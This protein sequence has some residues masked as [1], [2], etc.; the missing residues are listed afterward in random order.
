VPV[1]LVYRIYGGENRKGRPAYYRKR[2]SLASL[3]RAAE[4]AGVEVTTLADGPLP[5]DIR[6]MAAAFGDVVDLPGGPIGMRRSFWTGVTFPDRRGWSDNDVV[7]LCEDDYLHRLDAIEHL[8]AA[9]LALPQVSYFALSA[10]MADYPVGGSFT[11]PEDW[12]PK[13]DA[14]VGGIRWVQIPSATSTFGARV[15][16]L[17]ADRGIIRQGMLPYRSRLLDHEM[18][19]VWQGRFPYT[20]RE[21]FL[22]PAETRF[23]VGVREAAANAV[24]TPFRIAYQARALT[25][26]RAP[27]LMYATG[28]NLASHMESA[29][30]SPGTNWADVAAEADRWA[31]ERFG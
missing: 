18:C 23:R 9:A 19:L 17:R 4:H 1:H 25:R 2:T 11:Q 20:T 15:G 3:L 28:P 12:D 21:L 5:D 30:L 8:R 13:P 16:A 22:G 24:L 10:T 29:N 6:R 27:H 31:D 7:Y 26:R 14:V